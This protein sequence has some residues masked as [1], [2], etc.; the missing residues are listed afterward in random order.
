MEVLRHRSSAGLTFRLQ[1]RAHTDTAKPF[2]ASLASHRRRRLCRNARTD[3]ITRA[4]AEDEQQQQRQ[5]HSSNGGHNDWE[6]RENLV[7][8]ITA[9]PMPSP[10][11]VLDSSVSQPATK[12]WENVPEEMKR[13][14]QTP[15]TPDL[16]ALFDDKASAMQDVCGG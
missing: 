11:E 5:E 9:L 1:Q 2:G 14:V 16:S 3:T 12:T 15:G 6:I 13:K 4:P 10:Q 8:L 7:T